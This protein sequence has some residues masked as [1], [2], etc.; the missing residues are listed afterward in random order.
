MRKVMVGLGAVTLALTG[1]LVVASPASALTVRALG[2]YTGASARIRHSQYLSDP[3]INGLG[4]PG[5][6]TEHYCR[7]YGSSV[8]GNTYWQYHTNRRTRVT[9][10]TSE[11]LLNTRTAWAC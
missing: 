1:S 10:Y 6:R 8:S 3:V 9:G 11:T 2:D 4:Q 7:A 5:H